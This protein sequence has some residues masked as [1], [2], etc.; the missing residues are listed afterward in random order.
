MTLT[1]AELADLLRPYLSADDLPAPLGARFIAWIADAAVFAI[2]TWLLSVSAWMAAT[3]GSTTML[4]RLAPWSWVTGLI[5][6]FV[7]EG[8][9]GASLG[10]R[11]MGLRVTSETDGRWWLRVGVRTVVAPRPLAKL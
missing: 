9:W 8:G 6:Y 7:L 4:L 11:L 2:M 5:Y 3:V 10:K 1:K